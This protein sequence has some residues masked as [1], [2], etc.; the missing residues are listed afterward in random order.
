MLCVIQLD[1]LQHR[2]TVDSLTVQNLFQDIKQSGD[3]PLHMRMLITQTLMAAA[4]HNDQQGL[5]FLRDALRL[6]IATGIKRPLYESWTY[7]STMAD[8]MLQRRMLGSAEQELVS[9]LARLSA[10]GTAHSPEAPNLS[11]RERE[12][13]TMLA[14]GLSSKEMANRLRVSIGTVKGYRR[15]LYEKLGVTSRSQ[16]VKS[17][18][19]LGLALPTLQ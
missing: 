3:E 9:E 5:E 13:L 11:P 19:D 16:A 4:Q 7:L 8:S 15:K 6:A 2:G 14:Y 17:A 1:V 18:R 12:V 10:V